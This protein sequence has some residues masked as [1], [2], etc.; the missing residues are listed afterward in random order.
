MLV[1]TRKVGDVILI[2]ETISLYVVKVQGDRVRIGIDAPAEIPVLRKEVA[3]R[4]T[5]ERNIVGPG[6]G[7]P[8]L[9]R[10]TGS[11]RAAP[12]P[13]HR[14]SRVERPSEVRD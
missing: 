11:P 3:L 9:R 4:L 2:G 7:G 12:R 8:M 10:I 14:V 1:L 5:D 6:A 13:R